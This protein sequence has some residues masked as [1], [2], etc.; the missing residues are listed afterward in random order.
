MTAPGSR[1]QVTAPATARAETK[2][3][4]ADLL[5]SELTLASSREEAR[6]GAADLSSS[7]VALATARVENKD[8]AAN[9]LK[10]DAAVMAAVR[11]E[12]KIGVADLLVTV[13]ALAECRAET[14]TS[15]AELR[16]SE[17]ANT[18]LEILMRELRH[19]R[20]AAMAAN[21][22]KSRFLAGMS[23]ELRTPSTGIMGY[24]NLLQIEGGLNVAQQARV[25]SMLE[26]CKHLLEMI[27]GVLDLPEIEAGHL[28]L[29]L[30]QTD[31][32]ALALFH[33]RQVDDAH[34]RSGD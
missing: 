22:A 17:T 6:V 27:A 1:H 32:E 11:A 15:I 16:V 33:R 5:M 24:A 19:A 25:Q 3:S 31:P 10:S 14:K 28:T 21:E 23:H 8:G 30:T 20:D 29:R 2:V 7:L 13:A 18:G 9:L 4:L 26:A 34:R 12:M